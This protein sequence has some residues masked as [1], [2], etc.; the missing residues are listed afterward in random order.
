MEM[1]MEGRNGMTNKL[2][3]KRSEYINKEMEI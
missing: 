3:K 1:R 2:G